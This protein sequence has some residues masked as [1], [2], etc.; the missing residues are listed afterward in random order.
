MQA[1][2]R[3]MPQCLARRGVSDRFAAVLIGIIDHE[4]GARDCPARPPYGL[5]GVPMAAQ[6]DK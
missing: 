5:E 4:D 3:L 1:G 2:R 6:R